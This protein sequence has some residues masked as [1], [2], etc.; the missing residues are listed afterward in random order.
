M[1]LHSRF[2]ENPAFVINNVMQVVLNNYWVRKQAVQYLYTSDSTFTADCEISQITN[3]LLIDAL[4]RKSIIVFKETFLLSS[5]PVS[6][7]CFL[8]SKS[9]CIPGTSTMKQIIGL[10]SQSLHS[11]PT[12]RRLHV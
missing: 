4:M 5:S 3:Q 10:K 1:F 8:N 9:Y 2:P 11:I 6:V 7:F 12:A